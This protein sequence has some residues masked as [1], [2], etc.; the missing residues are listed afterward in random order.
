MDHPVVPNLQVCTK[1]LFLVNQV[2]VQTQIIIDGLG[3]WS[4][5][6]E[7]QTIKPGRNMVTFLISADLTIHLLD[8]LEAKTPG[9]SRGR[10]DY[11]GKI[12]WTLVRK[13]WIPLTIIYRFHLSVALANI[14]AS[15][16]QAGLHH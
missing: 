13:L 6:K 15:A 7:N 5:S 11:F 16:Y 12:F 3:R 8:T 10:K 4:D 1:K 9:Y 2:A 14:W